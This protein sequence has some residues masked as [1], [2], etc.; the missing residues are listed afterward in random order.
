M[1][2]GCGSVRP[3]QVAQPP[4]PTPTTPSSARM[5]RWHRLLVA[6][7]A[8]V[9]FYS[10]WSVIEQNISAF[11][12]RNA[13]ASFTGGKGLIKSLLFSWN[14][15]LKY[16][17]PTGPPRPLR[18]ET[19][20]PTDRP[21]RPPPMPRDPTRVTRPTDSPAPVPPPSGWVGP[22]DRPTLPRA[23]VVRKVNFQ[24]R[25]ASSYGVEPV[26]FLI[27]KQ[28]MFEHFQCPDLL[29]HSRLL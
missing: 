23:V 21:S 18:R 1:A 4:P 22:P 27:N 24:L 12:D 10:S 3:S 9:G 28:V 8:A 6:A 2:G 26:Q 25:L 17:R 19:G 7:L 13:T 5:G 14:C 15:V 29:T 20:W 11:A 16:C